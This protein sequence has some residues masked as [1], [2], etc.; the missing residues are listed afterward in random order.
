[1]TVGRPEPSST[2][3]TRQ[4]VRLFLHVAALYITVTICSPWLAGITYNVV[5]P[6]LGISRTG[7]SFQFLFSH[8]FAFS[9]IPAFIVGFINARYRHVVALFVWTVPAA[10]LAYK[11]ATF[12]T[13]VFESRFGAALHHYFG[14][15]FFI[16]EFHDYRD[17][18]RHIVPSVDARRGMD[19]LQFTAPVYGGIAY[20]LGAWLSKEY[21]LRK[22]FT[23]WKPQR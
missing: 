23:I 3:N 5:M 10:V 19:Q 21:L 13:S 11:F 8:L 20:S 6:G 7:S 4:V 15:N 9:F 16:P 18:F 14:G 1:M 2:S 12:P 17:L 22:L